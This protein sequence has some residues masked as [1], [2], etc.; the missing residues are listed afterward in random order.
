MPPR[1]EYTMF[2]TS[3]VFCARRT[4]PRVRFHLLM[5]SADHVERIVLQIR[6]YCFWPPISKPKTQKICP[7]IKKICFRPC[8]SRHFVY[9]LCEQ[10]VIL[11]L[12][13]KQKTEKQAVKTACFRPYYLF[14]LGL[15]YRSVYSVAAGS[16]RCTM[17]CGYGGSGATAAESTCPASSYC[18]NAWL[19]FFSVLSAHPARPL[20]AQDAWTG[21]GPPFGTA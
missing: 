6:L 8:L 10:I 17:L 19:A 20:T 2:F 3:L 21:T 13:R 12:Q 11:F 5:K 14:S 7:K 1:N 16:P 15:Q 4:E 9:P 18:G